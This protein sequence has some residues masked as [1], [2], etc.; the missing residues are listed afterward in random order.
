MLEFENHHPEKEVFLGQE[1]RKPLPL[2][3]PH[4]APGLSDSA[5]VQVLSTQP[6]IQSDQSSC[7]PND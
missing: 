3:A 4:A 7:N 1:G 5:K 2:G 6:A